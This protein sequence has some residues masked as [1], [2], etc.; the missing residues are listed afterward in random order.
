MR[1]P[2]LCRWRGCNKPRRGRGVQSTR[3][4]AAASR[5]LP[6]PRPRRPPPCAPSRL[7]RRPRGNEIGASRQLTAEHPG[8]SRAGVAALYHRRGVLGGR[9][10]SWA[11]PRRPGGE[12][13]LLPRGGGPQMEEGRLGGVAGVTVERGASPNL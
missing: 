12:R 8:R 4:A 2:N 13:A 1:V 3:V 11:T 9:R 10:W 7:P 6:S 5:L